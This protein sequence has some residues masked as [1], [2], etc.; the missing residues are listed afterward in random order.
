MNVKEILLKNPP[1]L[2][3]KQ[4]TRSIQIAWHFELQNLKAPTWNIGNKMPTKRLL[5]EAFREVRR[6][7]KFGDQNLANRESSMYNSDLVDNFQLEQFRSFAVL[8]VLC[9]GNFKSLGT[10]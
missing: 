3:G 10:F 2:S 6:S 4:A 8:M 9:V 1:R 7:P 5:S